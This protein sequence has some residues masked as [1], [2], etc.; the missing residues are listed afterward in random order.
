MQFLISEVVKTFDVVPINVPSSESEPLK[1]R[2]EVLKNIGE[3]KFAAR[4][5]RTERFRLQ[6]TFPQSGG[7]LIAENHGDHE[8]LIVDEALGLEHFQGSSVSQVIE[9]VE[10]AL[11]E[12]VGK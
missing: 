8:I 2:I 10:K 11:N 1:F 12:L 6:P 3:E 9:L 7:K 5:Y 4:I